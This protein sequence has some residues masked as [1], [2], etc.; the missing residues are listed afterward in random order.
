MPLRLLP[1]PPAK[2]QASN[3]DPAGL[4]RLWQESRRKAAFSLPKACGRLG[5]CGA[6]LTALNRFVTWEMGLA[7]RPC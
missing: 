7:A 5:R 4:G 2:L 3:R 6:A 1:L